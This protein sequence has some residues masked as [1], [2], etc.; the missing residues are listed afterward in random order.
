MLKYGHGGYSW[1]CILFHSIYRCMWMCWGNERS[2]HD[3]E[4]F[5]LMHFFFHTL[6]ICKMISLPKTPSRCNHEA[7]PCQVQFSPSQEKCPVLTQSPA[8]SQSWYLENV[9][10]QS[11][12]FKD[13]FIEMRM[14]DG[15][16]LT[17]LMVSGNVNISGIFWHKFLLTVF[18]TVKKV[19]RKMHTFHVV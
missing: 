14:I 18:T 11:F 3:S 9:S 13:K 5:V 16:C 2:Q 10:W 6:Y 1:H 4:D 7:F 8:L 19:S 15:K 17:E 12:P